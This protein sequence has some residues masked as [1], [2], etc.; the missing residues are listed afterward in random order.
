MCGLKWQFEEFAHV[1]RDYVSVSMYV[2][3]VNMY[4]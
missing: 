2:I 3:S 1:E 4:I